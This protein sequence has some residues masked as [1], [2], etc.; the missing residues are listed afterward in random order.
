VGAKSLTAPA[1]TKLYDQDF[2]AWAEATARLL[3]EG[4]LDQ[5]DIEILAEEVESMAKRD[6]AELR[7]R[8]R[9]LLMHLLKWGWQPGERSS[10]WHSTILEQ[11]SEMEDVLER[12]PS[13]RPTLAESV[14]RA[15]PAAAKRASI[16]TGLPLKV[17]PRECPFSVD[18]ILGEDFLPER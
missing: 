12:S 7:S 1:S 16:E 11:R 17:F 3:R 14:A 6:R 9:V 5:L 10:S 2:A 15:Y 18:Q 4:R 8:L 13:L